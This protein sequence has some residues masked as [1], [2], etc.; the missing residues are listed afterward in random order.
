[1]ASLI[2]VIIPAY[3]CEKFIRQALDSIL[4][5]T[6]PHLEIL[7]A[8]DA[9]KDRTKQIIDSYTD[10]RIRRFHNAENLGYLKTCNELFTQATGDFLAFQDADDYSALD[11]LEKQLLFL[12]H[13]PEVAVCGTNLTA[14]SEKGQFKYCSL[15]PRVHTEIK[16]SILDQTYSIIPNSFLLRREVYERIGG[17]HEF[18][19]RMGAE[20]Y[21]W[22]W[23]IMEKFQLTNLKEPLYY[24]RFN[25]NSISG[26][27]SDNPD[28]LISGKILK[29][30]INQR[31]NNGSDDLENGEIERVKK[32][33]Y[34]LFIQVIGDT[35]SF[36]HQ[37]AL[38]AFYSGSYNRSL[39]YQL[40]AILYRPNRLSAYKDFI[41]FML[42]PNHV[43]KI[44]R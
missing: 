26:D 17:Y 2:S 5:Q 44:K 4:Q 43:E 21:Y 31:V 8:D 12:E 27:L 33:K 7:M 14:I 38:R 29:F 1:M 30:L 19:N 39:I 28:K 3:N 41:Y 20:D 34:D 11:R 24:Y 23:L 6:Y 36:Y 10:P 9:S 37:L 15:Y 40:K 16:K 42:H 25:Q 13:N 32:Y 22:T 18:F 35:A